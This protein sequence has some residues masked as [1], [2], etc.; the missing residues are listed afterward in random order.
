M[1]SEVHIYTGK[2][3]VPMCLDET[4]NDLLL[5]C[6]LSLVLLIMFMLAFQIQ[7]CPKTEVESLDKPLF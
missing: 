5:V 3:K 1:E 6:T 2:P 4:C 7:I